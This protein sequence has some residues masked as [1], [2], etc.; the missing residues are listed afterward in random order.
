MCKNGEY[1]Y[2]YCIYIVEKCN[3]YLQYIDFKLF[4]VYIYTMNKNTFYKFE[5]F[6]L[7]YI[8]I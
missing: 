4:V 7:L 2:N 1:M 6:I 3:K 8:Y 5:I